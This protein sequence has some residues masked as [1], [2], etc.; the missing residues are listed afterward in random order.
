MPITTT[1]TW[2]D[3]RQA[4]TTERADLRDAYDELRA[5][6][7]DEYGD[8]ALDQTLPDDPD[9]VDPERKDLWVYQSQIKRYQQAAQTIDQRLNLLDRLQSEY[10]DGD[11][12][13]KLL[14]G[15]ETMDIETELR[16]EANQQNVSLDALA[17]QRNARTVDA[18]TVDAPEGV[19]T[20][21]DGSPT[22]SEC[23]NGLTLALYQQI[24]DLNSA[25]ETGFT[26]AGFG[27]GD[28]DQSPLADTSDPLPGAGE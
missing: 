12:E 9:A 3:L 27:D 22:P 16:M 19:P 10:G 13:I 20:D 7:T 2:A 23:P 15:S 14:S 25:G 4:L 24:N 1:V 8:D 6:A 5:Q 26:A 18:A 17:V 21:D 28:T 11:F